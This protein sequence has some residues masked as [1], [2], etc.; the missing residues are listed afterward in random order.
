MLQALS[1]VK[2]SVVNGIDSLFELFENGYPSV[3]EARK[4]ALKF[5]ANQNGYIHFSFFLME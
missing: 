4:N 3:T 2:A 1:T 5:T